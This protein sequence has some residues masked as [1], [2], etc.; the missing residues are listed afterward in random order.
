MYTYISLSIYLSIY[1]GDCG[2]VDQ[3]LQGHWDAVWAGRVWHPLWPRPRQAAGHN[4]ILLLYIYIY[5]TWKK[6]M[7][8]PVVHFVV[9]VAAPNFWAFLRSFVR[10]RPNFWSFLHS[11]VRRR[12]IRAFLRF[13]AR[14]RLNLDFCRW[15]DHRAFSMHDYLSNL[16]YL[17]ICS[18]IY[19]ATLRLPP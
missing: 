4:Y 13:F 9:C 12:P 10:R 3:Q 16:I 2:G 11:F 15:S 7:L 14:R 6:P 8:P 5:H 1:Q 19:L 17:S 18:S